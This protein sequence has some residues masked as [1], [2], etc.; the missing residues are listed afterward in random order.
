MV[1]FMNSHCKALS[2]LQW[3]EPRGRTQICRLCATIAPIKRLRHGDS[4]DPPGRTEESGQ[5]LRLA[6][7][8]LQEAFSFYCLSL[9]LPYWR[10]A[11]ELQAV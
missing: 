1:G 4:Q 2:L 10:L 11:A 5:R 3:G 6:T 7:H 8:V 9:I